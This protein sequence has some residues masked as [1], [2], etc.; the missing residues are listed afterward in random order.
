VQLLL[1]CRTEYELN[2]ILDRIIDGNKFESFVQGDDDIKSVFEYVYR[3]R[4]FYR[5]LIDKQPNIPSKTVARV[6]AK[7]VF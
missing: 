4:L 1:Q 2:N 5:S 3:S 6:L 7:S